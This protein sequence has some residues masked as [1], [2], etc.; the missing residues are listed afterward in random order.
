MKRVL[1]MWLLALAVLV[2]VSADARPAA[3]EGSPRSHGEMS[4]RLSR[5]GSFGRI[6]IQGGKKHFPEGAEVSIE[7]KRPEDVKRKIHQG[8]SKRKRSGK[9]A[10]SPNVLASYDISIRHG[11]RKWQPDAGDPVRV[12]VDLEAPVAITAASTLGVVHLADDGTV[13]ELPASRYG[14]TYNAARTAVTAFWFNA[15]GFSVYAIVDNAGDLVTPR[16]F[17]HFYDHPSDIDGSNAVQTFPYRYTDRS[18]DVINVQIVKDGDWLKEPPIPEDILDEHGGIVSMFEGWYV[19][20]SEPRP[21]SAVESKLDSTNSPFV[22]VWPVGVTDHR[23]SFTNGVEVA[24]SV[25]MDYY[26][27]PLFEHARFLQFNEVEREEHDAGERIIDRKIIALND[28][29]GV[30]QIK[31]SDVSAALKNSRQEYF[32]GWSYLDK[33]GQYSDLLMYSPTGTLQEAYIEIDDDLFTANGGNVIQLW[34]LYVSA[35]FLNFD[36]NAKGS[37]ATYVG[38]LF[39]RSTTDI[40]SV[41]PSGNRPGYDFDGWCVAAAANGGA[42]TLG[43]PVTD[44]SGN[45]YPNITATN[46]AGTVLL[47]TDASGNVRLNAD[48]TLYARWRANSSAPYRVIVWQQ[49]VTDAKDAAVTNKT[50]YYATHYTSPAVPATTQ[51]SDAL[52]TSFTGTRADGTSI[53][54]AANLTTLSGKAEANVANED[55][56]GFHY[57][58]YSCTDE[59]V[60]P[61][62]STVINLYYDRNLI[63]LRFCLYDSNQSE[64]IYTTTTSTSGDI[65]GTDDGENYFALYY[66]NGQWYKTRTSVPGYSYSNQYTGTRY[67]VSGSNWLGNPS[68]SETTSNEGTQYRRTGSF[69]NYTYYEI[70]YNASDGKWYQDRTEGTY[71]YSD[72]YSGYRYTVSTSHW[73]VNQTMTGLYGQTLASNGYT[74]PSTRRWYDGNNGSSTSGTQISFLD[75]FLPTS[76]GDE[77]FYS[78]TTTSTSSSNTKV[79]FYKENL[80]GTWLQANE[81]DSGSSSVNFNISDKYNGFEAYQYST[82]GESTWTSVGTYNESTHYYGSQVS[83]SKL[84][85]RFRRKKF[86]LIYKDGDETVYDT[87]KNVPYESSL[88]GYDLGVN[89]SRLDWKDRDTSVGTFEGWYEDA[90]L[91]V[92]FDFSATMK[93]GKKFLYAKWAPVKYKVIIDP[94]GGEMQSGDST[95][96]YLDAGEKIVEYTV[97]RNYRLNMHNGTYYY[98]HDLW[99]PVL[100]KHTDLYDPSTTGA[101]RRAYYTENIAEAT[102]NAVSN[103]ENRFSYE[104]NAYSFIGWYEVLENDELATDPFNFSEPPN[105]PVTIRAIWR[106]TSVY[107]LRYESIDPDGERPTEVLHDPELGVDGGYIDDGVTTLA[108]DPTNYDHEKWIWEGW[109]VVDVRNNNNPLTN[110]RSPGDVYVVHAEHADDRDNVIHFRAVYSL[111]ETGSSR[112]IPEVVDFVLDANEGAGLNANAAIQEQDGRLGMYTDGAAS[113]L[114]G[115]NAGVWFAGQQNNF[116]VNLADYTSAFAHQNG[117]FLLGWDTNRVNTTM[118]PAFY[119]NETIGVDKLGDGENVLYAVWEPQIYIEFVN[120]T[121]D[122]LTGIRLNIPAWLSGEVFRVNSVLDIYNRSLFSAFQDGSAT[123]NLAAGERMCLV[124]PDGEHKVFTVDG[125]S[126]YAEGTKLVITRTEP[127]I[128]G[129]DE[130]PDDVCTAY[131]GEHYLVTGTM[132][133]SPTPVQVRFTKSTYLTTTTVPVRY[134]LHDKSGTVTE[135]TQY[136]ASYWKSQNFKTNLTVGTSMSD[137]AGT[138]RTDTSSVGVHELLADN[139]RTNY[140]HTTI[141]I[142]VASAAI[143]TDHATLHASEYRS[144]TQEGASGGPYFRFY[145]EELKWSRYSQVWNG[146]DDP[147]IY[148]VFYKRTPV[149][150][151][152]AKN[153]VGSETDKTLPFAFSATYEERV[154]NV[155]YE[156]STAFRQTR[157]IKYTGRNEPR[158][159]NSVAGTSNV[160]WGNP[161]QNGSLTTNSLPSSLADEMNIEAFPARENDE[162]SLAHGERHPITIYYDRTPEQQIGSTLTPGGS[163]WNGNATSTGSGNNKVWSRTQVTNYTQKV[164]YVDTYQYETAVIQETAADQFTLTSITGDSDDPLASHTGTGNLAA[165]TYTISSKQEGSLDYTSLDTTIFTNSRKTGS[166]TVSKTVVDGDAGDAFSFIVTLGE[167]V[168]DKDN[169][170]PPAGVRLGP[171]GKV[172]T[173][174]LANGGSQTLTGLPAGATY[175]VEEAANDK[176]IATVPANAAGTIVA[177]TITTVGFTNTRKTDLSIVMKDSTVFFT[178]EEQRGRDITSVTGTGDTLDTGD[179]TVTGLAAGHVLTVEHHVAA[180]G[181]AVGSYVGHFENAR[182]T[183]HDAGNNDVTHAYVIN[184]TPG[185]LTIEPT[186]IIVTVTGNH[187]TETYNGREQSCEGYTYVIEHATTH[188]PIESESI[189]VSIP[190][191]YQQAFRTDV[192]R[193]DMYIQPGRVNVTVP[194]GVSV[195]NIVVAANGYIEITPAPVTVT[196]DDKSKIPG[197]ADPTLTATATGLIG[198]DTVSYSLSRAAGEAIGTYAITASGAAVQGN[199]AVTYMPGTFTIKALTLIQRATGEGLQ[200]TDPVSGSLLASLGIANQDDVTPEVVDGYLNQMDPNGLRRWENLRTGTDPSQ[201]LLSTSVAGTS[202]IAAQMVA[203]PGTVVDLGYTMLRE[204]RKERDGTWVRVAGPAAA[205]NPSFP[206]ELEDEGGNSVGAS[207]LYRVVTLL[208]PNQDLSITNEIPS[209][210]VIGVLEVDSAVSN[211][212]TAVPWKQLASDPV[213]ARDVTVSNFVAELNLSTGD[214][215]YT[216]DAEQ[217]GYQMWNRQTDGIWEPVTTVRTADDGSSL[218]LQAESAD[219]ARLPR[220]NAVWVRRA[221]TTKP[222]F[223]VGQYDEGE[224]TVQ[225][226]GKTAAGAGLAL[227]AIPTFKPVYLNKP[228]DYDGTQAYIDWSKFPV[229]ANDRIR[230]PVNGVQVEIEC[231]NGVWGTPDYAYVYNE[232]KKK[233]V[234][235]SVFKPYDEPIKVGTGFFYFRMESSGFTF[236]WK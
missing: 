215:V 92:P 100:D 91:T 219:V 72:P 135:I 151:T 139:V 176:Y 191:D 220:G 87:G 38:S 109:Q 111:R 160:Q 137:I 55:F 2:G 189:F 170:T 175:T 63:T 134:F 203:D 53:S 90:S 208:V 18:N 124:L 58:R 20:H 59:T 171:F 163:S 47:T 194:E 34:P 107:T 232:K 159:W 71:A 207:G 221:D 197:F 235:S 211:T 225:V 36:T 119:A 19:V 154:S 37:G 200:V 146:Y 41:T 13:E 218:A 205:G 29:T 54:T 152:V 9:N 65:Y 132:K 7:R 6:N 94:N 52:F 117:Y 67:I 204:L 57:A 104:P 84:S 128:A 120:D 110:I 214:E 182:V 209:T 78:T 185:S 114:G 99:D 79:Y 28:E 186:P 131:A 193:S 174:S 147:A 101:L 153:V 5:H 213:A 21:S 76:G 61:D 228:D 42:V 168:V 130:V 33:N 27:V 116:S 236:I 75:A 127:Q 192:G 51:I 30:A 161:Q 150:V 82:D 224:V 181:T 183:V 210:N 45:F 136:D 155:V 167:T 89:D 17:Y 1:Q 15:S 229:G 133:T 80:D 201:L 4:S 198:S 48:V 56:T 222:Y 142:G 70:Y 177:D 115:L 178:G 143:T 93:D 129:E 102:T 16:R 158:D 125:T 121:G 44:V 141:G 25:D 105:R 118:I 196:A 108:K 11:G 46:A 68:Y 22:F 216:L 123:F 43:M 187:A 226:P 86:E 10:A 165:G 112:H 172:F 12:T 138:L 26:V 3:Q 32:C 230:V 88:A 40:N 162:F 199:Y 69:L 202:Q 122:D 179:Y 149:H 190:P 195:S 233:M 212:I 217:R 49:R 23:L 173:F 144:I 39:I 50:Y 126:T 140:G 8:W 166:L 14:F 35:H 164:R 231:R 96:F 234:W 106:R 64:T 74:W 81:F 227:I 206:I 62:G 98:H 103:P 223:L 77:T 85:I 66:D 97:R 145:H 60:A 31:V 180:H 73:I 156:I 169:Y 148:V 83:S 184:T 95:W 24:E 157:T 188:E 113:A